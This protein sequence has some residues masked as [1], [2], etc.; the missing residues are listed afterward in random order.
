MK[1]SAAL[2]LA[3]SA[4]LIY[5]ALQ[6]FSGPQQARSSQPDYS[7]LSEIVQ[8]RDAVFIQSQAEATVSELRAN[9][10]LLDQYSQITP[11]EIDN[12]IAVR[13]PPVVSPLAG[14]PRATQVTAER[15]QE[16]LLVKPEYRLSMVFVG[17]GNR[18]AVVNGMFREEGDRM[19]EGGILQSIGEDRVVIENSGETLVV[20][21]Q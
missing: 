14:L 8:L 12:L 3:I 9:L 21:M 6:V 2:V 7:E 15:G 17:P 1:F 5:G 20:Q 18:F 11:V 4:L 10:R 19:P 13:P 16:D